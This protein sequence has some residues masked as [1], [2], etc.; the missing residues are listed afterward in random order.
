MDFQELTKV[1][2]RRGLPAYR[3]QQVY[4]AYAKDLVS[5]WEEVTTLPQALRTELSATCPWKLAET[6]KLQSSR[7][8]ESHK[9]LLTFSDRASTE[10]VLLKMEKNDWTA[11][12]S[13]QVGCPMNCAFCATGKLGLQRN[14]SAAEIIEQIVFWL[15]FLQDHYP[16]D[17]LGNVVY[18][19][20]GEPLLNLEAVSASIAFLTDKKILGWSPSRVSISTCGIVPGIKELAHDKLLARVNL[21]I[22]LHAPNQTLREKLMPVAKRYPL[23]ELLDACRKYVKVTGGKIFFEYVM[24]AGINDSLEQASE[25]VRVLK[26]VNKAHV[27]LIRFN[28]SHGAH[29]EASSDKQLMAFQK[30]LKTGGL[31]CTIRKSLGNEIS[32]ACGQLAGEH[33]S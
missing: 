2:E 27:N 24:L 7:A 21:A 9:A 16:G 12:V 31:E 8:G 11:C 3:L 33:N 22:S 18:M 15:H 20:M 19:G 14:L 4:Q 32:G 10:T 30:V 13:C 1:F 25:L 6:A 29:F 28:P 5:S 26:S 23:P 17:T